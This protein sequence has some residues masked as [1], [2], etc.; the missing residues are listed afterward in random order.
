MS[1]ATFNDGKKC[2]VNIVG[3]PEMT[4]SHTCVDC[5]CLPSGKLIVSGL[6]ATRLLSKLAP[7]VMKMKVAPVSAMA[8]VVTIVNAFRYYGVGQPNNLPAAEARLVFILA[9]AL[10]YG[11]V[12]F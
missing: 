8:C 4:M 7:S 1:D 11:T 2:L 12:T 9:G 3:S 6:T 10:F 5:T